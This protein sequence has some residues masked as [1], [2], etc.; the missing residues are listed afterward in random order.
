MPKKQ[1]QTFNQVEK[2]EKQKH[3]V[4]IQCEK[5][6]K[7]N[8]YNTNTNITIQYEYK[9]SKIHKKEV[10]YKNFEKRTKK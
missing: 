8:E 6:L 4:G 7:L 1:K 10:T 2:F 5:D 3:L 9:H